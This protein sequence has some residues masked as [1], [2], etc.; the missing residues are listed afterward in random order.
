[1]TKLLLRTL[2]AF[3]GG[4]VGL[5]LLLFLSAGTFDYW[6]A[7]TFIPVLLIT[8]CVFRIYFSIKDPA[9]MARRRRAGPTAEQSTLQKVVVTLALASLLALP[10]LSALD[11]RFGWSSVPPL[12]SW[13]GDALLVLSF[14][15]FS[16]VF[17]VNSYGSANIQVE[18]D[19]TVISTGPYALV[20]HPMYD[21]AIVLALGIP[22]A[23]GSWWAL[24]AVLVLTL[25][26]LVIRILNEERT[27]AE[28]LPGYTDYQQKAR[29][30]LVPHLW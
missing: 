8:A 23:L 22:L 4:A 13:I 19:Q 24:L 11:R 21:A 2:A 7:W 1:M 18:Q 28:H 15:M 29:Y 10:V 6:Q 26:A 14:L 16:Y 30:R 9:L 17:S 3:A 12:V 5:G 25:P 20:R 27:L